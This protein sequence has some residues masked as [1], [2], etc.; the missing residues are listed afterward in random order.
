MRDTQKN[1]HLH[2][3]ARSRRKINRRERKE[4]KK[5]RGRREGKGEKER[6]MQSHQEGRDKM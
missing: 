3:T 1:T 2:N 4:K 5:K 6:V